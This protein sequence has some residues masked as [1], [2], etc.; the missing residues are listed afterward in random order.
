MPEGP[1]LHLA[2]LYVNKVCNGLCFGG[3]VEKSAVSKNPEVPFSCPAYTISAVSRGKEVKL[4]LTPVAAAGE[5]AC[6]V[7]RFGMSGSF[8][9]TPEDEVPKHA[10]LRFY[11]MDVPRQVL[12]FVDPRRFGS[13]EYNG[14]WQ[15]QRGPCVMMESEKFR[16]NVLNHLSDKAFDKPICDVM[17]NQKYFNGIGNY[18]RAEILFRLKIPPFMPARAVLESVKDQSQDGDISLSKKIKIK[19]ENPDFLQLCCLVP[20]EVIKL[21]GKGYDPGSSGDFTAFE[22]WLQCY[23]VPGM[24][25][26]KDRNG[27][28]IWF[29]GEPGPLAP[30][31][32]KAQ[33]QHRSMAMTAKPIKVET[34]ATKRKAMRDKSTAVKKECKD[35]VK[36]EPGVETAV[37]GKRAKIAENSTEDAEMPNKGERGKVSQRGKKAVDDSKGKVSRRLSN[38]GPTPKTPSKRG[39]ATNPQ[40]EDALAPKLRSRRLR[41]DVVN[42]PQNSPKLKPSTRNSAL[43][44]AK[45]K[46]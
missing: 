3:K 32:R 29:Q 2:S 35:E 10:H 31:G 33:I 44:I 25:T 43:H 23:Y 39:K 14:T 15:P 12:C 26:L 38:R 16:E 37:K 40:S 27:R 13:W 11:T 21:G 18:L 1:E 41:S 36:I 24:K 42:R 22:Q 4:I 5:V 34:H 6:V 30:K 20:M 19:K 17:L 28:T 8:K 9:F 46:S 7:I 45:S